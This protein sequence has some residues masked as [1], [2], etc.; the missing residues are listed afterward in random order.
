M[1]K[2]GY[3]YLDRLGGLPESMFR[4][5]RIKLLI[6]AD[7]IFTKPVEKIVRIVLMG[8]NSGNNLQKE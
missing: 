1:T 8:A 6:T 5:F 3:L 4:W 2:N 7:S